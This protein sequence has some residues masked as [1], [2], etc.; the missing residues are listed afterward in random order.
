MNAQLVKKVV[1][2]GGGTAGWIAAA[3]LV[4]QL[5]PLLDITLVESD[6]IA[7]IGVGESTIPTVRAFHSLLGIDERE[8]M[9]ATQSSFKL[10]IAFE[11]WSA[12]G[13]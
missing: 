6:E 2:A 9:R 5:G 11:D 12:I 8:F 4:K 13:D 7:T 1:I 3:A 10:G